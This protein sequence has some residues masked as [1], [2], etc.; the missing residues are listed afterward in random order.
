[1]VPHAMELIIRTQLNVIGLLKTAV[2]KFIP[3]TPVTTAKIVT[4][5]V[6]AVSN[7]SNCISWF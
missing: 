6:A 3:K 4:T 7:N 1:M 2:S 5:N